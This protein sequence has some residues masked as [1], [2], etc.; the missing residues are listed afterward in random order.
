MYRC[1]QLQFIYAEHGKRQRDEQYGYPANDGRGLQC[2]LYLS[3]GGAEN[4]ACDG[5]GKC[6][7]EDVTHREPEGFAGGDV[8]ALS[9]DDARQNRHHGQAA[10]REGQQQAEPQEHAH[11]GG[12]ARFCD[13]PGQPVL[14]GY[15][16][17]RVD[18]VSARGQR[19]VDGQRDSRGRIADA[20]FLAALVADLQF[21]DLRFRVATRKRNHYFYGI[22]VD[23]RF[24][25]LDVHFHPAF[26]KAARP[27]V[28]PRCP[29]C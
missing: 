2:G 5:V 4:S 9:R 8:V 28:A 6:H 18:A 1:R 15:G 19:Q 21:D 20:V 27:P 25:E 13:D 24:A 11:D 29:D 12:Q 22:V 14:L 3:A 26:G 7:A 17:R 16:R 23:L 10:W